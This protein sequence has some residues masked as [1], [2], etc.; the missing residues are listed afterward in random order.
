M[1]LYTAERWILERHEAVIRTAET[2]SRLIPVTGRARS[3]LWLA[4]HLRALADRLDGQH[5]HP[6]TP[7]FMSNSAEPQRPTA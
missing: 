6:V 1:D 5:Q 3:S 4:A 2:R 7:Q